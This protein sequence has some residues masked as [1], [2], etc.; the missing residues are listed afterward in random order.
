MDDKPFTQQP[1]NTPFPWAKILAEALLPHATVQHYRK[2]IRLP[3]RENGEPICRIVVSGSVEI[4]RSS[5]DLVVLS[6]LSYPSIIGLGV[7]DVYLVT[8]ES[9]NI[10]T[11]SVAEMHVHVQEQNLWEVLAQHMTMLTNK[12]YAYSKQ[13]SAPTAYEMICNQLMSLS[14]EPDTLRQNISVE[15][16][17]REKTHLSRSSIMKILADLRVGGYVVIENGRLIEIKH[18]PSKY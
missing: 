3:L 8:N 5:D 2:G 10:A 6:I 17:I 16:Y 13:L 1:L 14:Y 4:H 18:L 7:N 12:L 9:C 15:R 11:M